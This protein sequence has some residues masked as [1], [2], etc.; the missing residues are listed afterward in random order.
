L[1]LYPFL[2]SELAAAEKAT[3]VFEPI[4]LSVPTTTT[5]IN[6]RISAYFRNVLALFCSLKVARKIIHISSLRLRTVSLLQIW[7]SRN[8][9]CGSTI[10]NK[11]GRPRTAS[12]M[13]RTLEKVG[14]SR[15]P[16]HSPSRSH[17]TYVLR[18]SFKRRSPCCSW[19]L[20][21]QKSTLLPEIARWLAQVPP[22]WRDRPVVGFGPGGK[23]AARSP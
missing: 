12:G 16:K 1:F 10:V 21:A 18:R 2:C 19:P 23:E 20:E 13:R 4:N 14:G 5:N 3:F 8:L 11:H 22:R 7:L 6:A 15:A 9:T 17:A